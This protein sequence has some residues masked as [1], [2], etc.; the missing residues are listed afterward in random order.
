MSYKEWIERARFFLKEAK[1]Y[2]EAKIFW[3]SC[4]N[5]HQAVEFYLKGLLY[6]K[7]RSYPFTHDL[8]F[9]LDELKKY[10]IDVPEEI[11]LSA[12]YLT[13]HYTGARYPGTRAIIY[14][15]RRGK[16]CLE[17]ALKISNFVEKI[18]EEL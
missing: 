10:K 6:K 4:F 11:Y 2:L 14:D 12:D 16:S 1:R 17:H 13:P 3:A 18:L 8:L 5:A 7:T 9:L 15:E